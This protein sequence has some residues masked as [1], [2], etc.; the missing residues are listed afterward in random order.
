MNLDQGITMQ[1]VVGETVKPRA[2]GSSNLRH[3]DQGFVLRTPWLD[4]I[5]VFAGKSAFLARCIGADIVFP[6]TLGLP[7]A[8]RADR[9]ARSLHWAATAAG[10]QIGAASLARMWWRPLYAFAP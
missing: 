7:S 1:T 9:A 6:L 5:G 3:P 2:Q 4:A 10:V 8:K